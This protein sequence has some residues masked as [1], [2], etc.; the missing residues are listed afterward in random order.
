MA[1]FVDD[2]SLRTCRLGLLLVGLVLL[3]LLLHGNHLL[4]LHAEGLWLAS[5]G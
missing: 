2:R 3:L 1:A 4:E 5:F